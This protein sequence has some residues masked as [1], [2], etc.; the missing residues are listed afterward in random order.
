MEIHRKFKDKIIIL[1]SHNPGKIRE[2]A[3]LLNPY[4]LEIIFAP[5][6]GLIEPEETGTTFVENAELKAQYAASTARLPSLSEDSGLVVPALNGA[7]GVYSARWAGD[8]KDYSKAMRKIEQLIKRHTDRTAFFFTAMSLCWPDGHCETFKGKIKGRLV[9][10]PRG[11]LG[12]GYDPVFLPNGKRKTFGE[13]LPKAKHA[14]SHRA[15]A[16]AKL[17]TACFSRF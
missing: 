9:W 1:A 10:P 3:E 5:D 17:E 11:K 2:I 7:P 16:F 8:K 6:L 12:F 13:M 4:K 14:I 15:N